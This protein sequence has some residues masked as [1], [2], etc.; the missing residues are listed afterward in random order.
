MNKKKIILLSGQNKST[1]VI[2]NYLK[3]EFTIEKV[4][5]EKHIPMGRYFKRRMKTL[6][7]VKVI[8]QLLFLIL[9]VPLLKIKSRNRFD[10]IK[11]KYK[12]DDN[13][14]EKSET[15]NLSSINSIETIKILKKYN[16]SIVVINGTRIISEKILNSI[17][18]KFIN[19]HAGITPLYR[20]LHGGYWAL[21]ENNI[22]K[23]GV[24]VHLVDA[25]IDTG[26]ILEQGLI[27]PSKEDNFV[28]YPLLQLAEGLPLLKKAI[29]AIFSNKMVIKPYPEGISK[30][31][32]HPTFWE[33]LF[34][35]IHFRIK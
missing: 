23:C 35:R 8:G 12:L 14:I 30:F 9:I 28:T 25:G 24:T 33:Y 1:N 15:L 11:K 3:K 32:S 21:T 27:K 10:L 6:G 31:W 22:T 29:N 17:D 4:I 34:F 18:T 16:P 2:F 5:I 19:T 20:G 7:I 13:S 26:N